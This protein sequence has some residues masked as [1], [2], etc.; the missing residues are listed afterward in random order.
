MEPSMSSWM[1]AHTQKIV[2]K[3]YAVPLPYNYHHDGKVAGG[4]RTHPL[5]RRQKLPEFFWESCGNNYQASLD[6]SDSTTENKECCNLQITSSNW[7]SL[8]VYPHISSELE[9]QNRNTDKR[10]AYEIRQVYYSQCHNS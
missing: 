8:I 5:R 1:L 6:Q 4:W 7:S 9:N 10:V 2:K 3:K